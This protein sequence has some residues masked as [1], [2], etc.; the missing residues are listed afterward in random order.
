MIVLIKQRDG[1]MD[2]SV[3]QFP[4]RRPSITCLRQESS[5]SLRLH[6]FSCLLLLSLIFFWRLYQP[7]N[8]TGT[9]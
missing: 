2:S 1:K 9:S 6:R 7:H 4:P 8:G 3:M 5:G